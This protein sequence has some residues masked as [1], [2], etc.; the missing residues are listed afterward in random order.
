MKFKKL[1]SNAGKT[2]DTSVKAGPFYVSPRAFRTDIKNLFQ[3]FITNPIDE[4]KSILDVI[5]YMLLLGIDILTIDTNAMIIHGENL[6]DAIVDTIYYPC[7]FVVELATALIT[8]VLKTIQL[9]GS[10]AID[11]S[12]GISKC[13]SPA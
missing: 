9:F 12:E 2:I 8:L 4:M 7:K 10:V 3:P 5:K 1:I 6:L 13:L 11:I